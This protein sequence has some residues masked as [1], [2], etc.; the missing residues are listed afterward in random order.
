[1]VIDFY[2]Q[3]KAQLSLRSY[4]K[5]GDLGQI[6]YLHG[7]IYGR[8]C[9]YDYTFEGYVAD[10]LSHFSRSYDLHQERLWLAEAE[11]RIVGSIGI[12]K[13]NSQRCQLRWFLVDPQMRGRGLGRKLL[14]KA[15]K[16][17]QNCGYE[18]VFLQTMGELPVARHLY[19]SVGFVKTEESKQIIWGQKVT[20]QFYELALDNQQPETYTQGDRAKVLR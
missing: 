15:I 4:L 2:A 14:S 5:P 12:I 10:T 3:K 7:S 17:S 20:H 6:L 18:S 9:G 13:N 11:G 19:R 8:E 16:F 1:M